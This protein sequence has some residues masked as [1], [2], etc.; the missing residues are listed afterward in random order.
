MGMGFLL[1]LSVG[2]SGWDPLLQRAVASR[3]QDNHLAAV[4]TP[5][6]K[7]SLVQ[8]PGSNSPPHEAKDPSRRSARQSSGHAVC[9]IGEQLL[10]TPA[11]ALARGSISTSATCDGADNSLDTCA[12]CST[13]HSVGSGSSAP[14]SGHSAHDTDARDLEAQ[15]LALAWRLQQ[16]EQAALAQAIEA[17]SPMPGTQNFARPARPATPAS[18][19]R[20]GSVFGGEEQSYNGNGAGD[21][22]MDL[23]AD[24]ASLRLALR[25]QQEELEWHEIASRRTI[26]EA[27]SSTPDGARVLGFFN[28][29]SDR[30][31]GV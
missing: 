8:T 5:L 26:S 24:D 11:E 30:D 3:T 14:L 23:D 22:Q 29:A 28:G 19:A 20:Q 27:M 7:P 6:A 13:G 21:E 31:Q 10:Q 17:N 4:E 25:L 2:Y 1:P 16:E 15:S 9:S 18:S 12:T